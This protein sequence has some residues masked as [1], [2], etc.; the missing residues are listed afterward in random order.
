MEMKLNGNNNSYVNRLF[1][2]WSLFM[3][4][5]W[6]SKTMQPIYWNDQGYLDLFGISYVFMAIF[7][8]LSIVYSKIP[9]TI[10][11]RKSIILGGIIY[12]LGLGLRAI[13]S[14]ISLA[15]I[16]GAFCGM[17]SILVFLSNRYWLLSYS[18]EDTRPIYIA[19]INLFSDVGKNT[20]IFFSGVLAMSI[21]LPGI[22]GERFVLILSSILVLI[23]IIIYP[24]NS[25]DFDSKDEVKG[26]SLKHLF[27]TY[28][29]KVV[30]Q[31]VFLLF[32]G[33]QSAILIPVLPLYIKEFGF[34]TSNT[35]IV[36][37]IAAGLGTAAQY[38]Y[39][40]KLKRKNLYAS[41]AI[42]SILVALCTLG[43]LNSEK[44][45]YVFVMFLVVMMVFRALSGI[46]YSVGQYH[47]FQKDH[48]PAA[49]GLIQTTFIL[50]DL[51]GG[52]LLSYVYKNNLLIEY[53]HYFA[54]LI[55]F[56]SMIYV[57]L[58]RTNE[59]EQNKL[60]K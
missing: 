36:L 27:K 26:G 25:S 55:F 33:I 6:M 23:A 59:S 3:F 17:G 37:S 28:P 7:G 13:P 29:G 57:F 9:A 1:L 52:A 60:D 19:K 47:L 31:I 11:I 15:A 44:S 50:G 22:S 2:F 39:S 51:A 10:G 5:M 56:N 41:Y 40:K 49:I 35:T 45:A 54:L 42:V 32:L 24:K 14:T 18:D 53:K 4:S 8:S 30:S 12:S 16:S 48:L 20:G 21:T 46:L 38:L 43:F 58:L 34:S